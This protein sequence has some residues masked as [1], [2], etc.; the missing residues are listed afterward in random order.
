MPPETHARLSASSSKRWIKC[1]RSVALCEKLPQEESEYA[2]EGRL[3][4]AFAEKLLRLYAQYGRTDFADCETK[5][6]TV[7]GAEEKVDQEMRNAI[8]I[9][10]KEIS[11]TFE[12]LRL[13][14]PDARM[15]IEQKVVFDHWVPGGFGTSDCVIVSQGV[16]H[17]FDLKYGKGVM[18]D[19]QNNSQL[20][21]YALGAYEELDWEAD[22]ESFETH[23]VQPR[24]NWV[25]GERISKGDLLEWGESLKPLAKMADEDRGEFRSGPWCSE[26]FCPA[27]D[28]CKKRAHDVVEALLQAIDESKDGLT[29]ELM[30]EGAMSSFARTAAPLQKL[31]GDVSSHLL[32]EIVNGKAH[33]GWK[34]V[35]GRASRDWDDSEKLK[36]QLQDRGY[37]VKDI[38]EPQELLSPNK[39]KGALK[40]ADYKEIALPHI[41]VE[42]GKPQLAEADDPRDE[43]KPL[44]AAE[45]FKGLINQGGS[46]K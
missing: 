8:Q 32:T 43:Y 1:P 20:R 19:G 34:A 13:K 30:G 36:K 26:A 18:V 35:S 12:G 15:L 46:E 4:H 5:S 27:R 17:V 6:V 33:P 16:C 10:V 2:D 25:S 45:D 44:S 11:E 42:P 24:L 7:D 31:C 39:L 29:P 9:Y 22:I 21:L 28:M 40:A 41:T 38:T 3:A 14:D 37:L 23:I